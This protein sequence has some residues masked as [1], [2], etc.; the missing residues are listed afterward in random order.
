MI[1]RIIENWL[2]NSAEKTFQI[3]FCYILANEGYT[4]VHLTRHCGMEHGKDVIAI[5]PFGEICAY[6]LKNSKGGKIKLKHYQEEL[7]PQIMQLVHTPVSHPSVPFPND[8]ISYF[9]TNGELEEEVFRE[10]DSFNKNWALKGQPQYQVRTILKGELLQKALA[11]KSDLVPS[12]VKDY[13]LLIDFHLNDGNGILEKNKFSKLLEDH[14]SRVPAGETEA[15]RTI[16]SGALL[17]SLATASYTNRNNYVPVIEAWT[18]Y[19]S[20][21]LWYAESNDL[22]APMYK[23]EVSIA[24][25]IIRNALESLLDELSE[26]ENYLEG[27]A[28]EDAFV[29]EFRLTWLIGFVCYLGL[30]YKEEDLAVVNQRVESIKKFVEGNARTMK[31]WGESAMPC[32][33]MEYWFRKTFGLDQRC[34]SLKKGVDTLIVTLL[35]KEFPFASP[36]EDIDTSL[37]NIFGDN[38]L[39]EEIYLL[40]H[41]S[42]Y[43]RPLILLLVREGEREFLQSRWKDISKIFFKHFKPSEPINVYRW[44]IEQGED[45]T[46]TVN[47]PESWQNLSIESETIHTRT[48]PKLLLEKQ[49]LLPLFLLVFPHR[50]SKEFILVIDELLNNARQ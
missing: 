43:L 47:T 39:R 28:P 7:L 22:S 13:K 11:L 27:S 30:Y 10:I 44:R 26:R 35:R 29:F 19:T 16:S 50:V 33:L 48:I 6:Q 36:Y 3:P 32:L 31:V 46:T 18:I 9:V 23:N 21:L 40:K 5:S 34:F 17:C 2:I 38:S 45:V 25:E 41:Q 14:F 12:E 37:A 15:K 42:Y 1:E 20:Y 4:V 8:H 49:W 24:E